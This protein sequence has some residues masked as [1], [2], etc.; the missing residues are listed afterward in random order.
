VV[1]LSCCG[2]GHTSSVGAVRG[3]ESC[4]LPKPLVWGSDEA[5]IPQ[6][7]GE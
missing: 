5:I 1:G 4:A 2:Y 3:N 7:L 6:W